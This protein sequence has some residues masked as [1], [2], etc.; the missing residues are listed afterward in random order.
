VHADF[1][2]AGVAAR[3]TDQ[4]FC[5][6]LSVSGCGCIGIAASVTG[7]RISFIVAATLAM[8]LILAPAQI[9]LLCCYR[10]WAR[11]LPFLWHRCVLRMLGV[12]VHVSGTAPVQRPLLIVAN[13]VSWS[14]ILILGSIME[15]CFIAKSEV[16][17]WPGINL[18]AWLQRTVFI[19]RSRRNDTR[20]Q[21][22][23]VAER[24]LQGDAV[25]LFAEGTTGDGHRIRPFKSALFGAIR[26]AL[27]ISK[28]DHLT[29]QPVAIGYTR[30]HG[31]PLGRLH[32]ARAAWPGDVALLPH[33]FNFVAAGA[34]DVEIAFCEPA[35]I[36]ATTKRRVISDLAQRRIRRDFVSAMR[37]ALDRQADRRYSNDRNCIK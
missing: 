17:S 37:G 1:P 20:N 32:Q 30:L 26:F 24:L 16:K 25:V 18:L 10:R 15:L 33:L 5:N 34:Y 13:H 2:N 28:Q 31:L 6:R 22:N 21:A 8:T 7:L 36:S 12:R 11:R 23:M 29:V 27:E 3:G 14:D 19:E 35:D 4:L 9:A